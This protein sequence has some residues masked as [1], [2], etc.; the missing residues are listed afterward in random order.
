[1][2]G[3][4]AIE[5]LEQYIPDVIFI[6]IRLPLLDG[7]EILDYIHNSPRLDDM[8]VIVITADKSVEQYIRKLERVEFLLK[9]VYPADI[10]KLVDDI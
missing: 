3:S 10:R 9:P 6:D 7:L 2:D 4:V 1:M 5:L 8:R